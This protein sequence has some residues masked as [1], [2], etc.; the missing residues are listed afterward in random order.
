M[1]LSASTITT[2]R[3]K[4]GCDRVRTVR[5]DPDDAGS[6]L[7]PRGRA[8]VLRWV[9]GASAILGHD[10]SRGRSAHAPRRPVEDQLS[11]TGAVPGWFA[12]ADLPQ[13]ALDAGNGVSR[14]AHVGITDGRPM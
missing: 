12:D 5:L 3:L 7:K 4:I 9:C 6:V 2:E 14:K 8:V 13:R 10:D 11:P 1:W